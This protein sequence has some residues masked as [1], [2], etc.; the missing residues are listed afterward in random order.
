MLF[1]A[2]PSCFHHTTGMD[3]FLPRCHG[4]AIDRGKPEARV[5]HLLFEGDNVGLIGVS[6][7]V[8]EGLG[9][10]ALV[11]VLFL[12]LLD[13]SGDGLDATEHLSGSPRRF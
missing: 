13:A 11:L 2:V 8:H 3:L 12:R 1:L 5:E 6:V 10:P 4:N 9:V 7:I